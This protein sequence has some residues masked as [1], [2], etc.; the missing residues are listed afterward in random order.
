MWFTWD[1]QILFEGVLFGTLL[2][3]C[4]KRGHA[5][6]IYPFNQNNRL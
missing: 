1:N 3:A 6:W 5:N 2:L 4:G